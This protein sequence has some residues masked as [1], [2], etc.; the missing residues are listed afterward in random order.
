[1]EYGTDPKTVVD[2]LEGVAAKQPLVARKPAPKVIF[3][4]FGENALN[5]QLNVWFPEAR[6]YGAASDLRLA[7][8]DALVAAGIGLAYPQR[9][10]HLRTIAPGVSLE[11]KPVEDGSAEVG[12]PATGRP[13]QETERDESHESHRAGTHG[14]SDVP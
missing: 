2:V 13:E 7:A 5:F 8:S 6:W 11:I 3:L 12:A 1:V 10:L 14:V 9:D 4:G